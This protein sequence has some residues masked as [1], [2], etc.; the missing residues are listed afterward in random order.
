[1]EKNLGI[2]HNDITRVLMEVPDKSIDTLYSYVENTAA[3][4][5]RIFLLGNGGS[6][7]ICNH[8]AIDF[9]KRL[10]IQA[11]S[12]SNPGLITCYA[13]DYGFENVY[14]EWLKRYKLL[15]TDLVI[16]ISSSG[17]SKDII[18]GLNEARE[19]DARTCII[20]GFEEKNPSYD[21]SIYLDSDNYGVVELSTEI[22]LHNIVE[23][24][25]VEKNG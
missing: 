17:N 23:R 3:L 11:E 19:E 22:I 10:N 24:M 13:N 4:E 16:G 6:H 15:P 20:Y 14:A 12:L 8:I 5:N 9:T 7:T 1:M 25:V 21:L 2:F 18:N